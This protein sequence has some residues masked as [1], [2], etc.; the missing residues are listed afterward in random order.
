MK[1]D[2]IVDKNN[3]DLIKR[4][5]KL[6]KDVSWWNADDN[7]SKVNNLTIKINELE[8]K[9]KILIKI[10]KKLKGKIDGWNK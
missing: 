9:L 2:K 4:I 10:V 5:E 6:E 1:N 8:K 7:E 3:K